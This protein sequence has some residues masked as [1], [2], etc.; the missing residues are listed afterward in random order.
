MKGGSPP[1]PPGEKPSAADAE[2]G[3]VE[4][5]PVKLH[6][7]DERQ[8]GTDHQACRHKPFTNNTTEVA[9]ITNGSWVTLRAPSYRDR[10]PQLVV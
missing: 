6:L 3:E 1:Q 5:R 10:S 8:V 7:E 9:Q 2:A 4:R